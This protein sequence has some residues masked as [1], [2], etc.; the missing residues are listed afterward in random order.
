MF[1]VHGAAPPFQIVSLDAARLSSAFVVRVAVRLGGSAWLG[2]AASWLGQ[3]GNRQ[4]AACRSAPATPAWIAAGDARASRAPRVMRVARWW[5]LPPQRSR[6]IWIRRARLCVWLRVS[7]FRPRAAPLLLPPP[8]ARQRRDAASVLARETRARRL[9]LPLRSSPRQQRARRRAC[10]CSNAMAR[11]SHAT[12]ARLVVCSS[13]WCPAACVSLVAVY[14]ALP[15]FIHGIS[16]RIHVYPRVSTCIH[17]ASTFPWCIHGASTFPWCIH[18][19]PRA[20][21]C[22]HG[23]SA[24]RLVNPRIGISGVF[25]LNWLSELAAVRRAQSSE[26]QVGPTSEVGN[27]PTPNAPSCQDGAHWS[28]KLRYKGGNRERSKAHS[29]HVR[30][31][32]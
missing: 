15:W 16:T 17:G 26:S 3:L 6:G 9:L 20:S 18:V 11:A 22:I 25:P 12:R 13:F 21:T 29:Y 32:V 1:V 19:Y 28:A 30:V 10:V 8:V 24:L 27:P 5:L 2:T 14:P 4:R 31:T 23:K 7:L